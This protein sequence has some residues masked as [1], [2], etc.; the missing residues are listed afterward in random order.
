MGGPYHAPLRVR[1]KFSVIL[2]ISQGP[3]WARRPVADE[4]IKIPRRK[5]RSQPHCSVHCVQMAANYISLSL[6][7]LAGMAFVIGPRKTVVN[8]AF[9]NSKCLR[10]SV[11]TRAEALQGDL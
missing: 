3:R 7:V 6:A 8:A 5:P 10:Y 11:G 2:M 9:H 4:Q 1:Y